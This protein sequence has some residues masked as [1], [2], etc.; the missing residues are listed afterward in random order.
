[1]K[2]AVY[3]VDML[4]NTEDGAELHK[5]KTNKEDFR[6]GQLIWVRK[7][8]GTRMIANFIGYIDASGAGHVE[9]IIER[10]VAKGEMPHY[11]KVLQRNLVDCPLHMTDE[12]YKQY[13]TLFKRNANTSKETAELKLTR[14]IIMSAK[15]FIDRDTGNIHFRYG[16][17]EIIT[18]HY[19]IIGLNTKPYGAKFTKSWELYKELNQQLGIKLTQEEREL[20]GL[21]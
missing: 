14:N 8:N 18:R 13:V 5:A 19:E 9:E 17:Q 4:Y 1:M 16:H 11:K 10:T 6:K 7:E 21:A 15:R 3:N 12:A 2:I 20:Y